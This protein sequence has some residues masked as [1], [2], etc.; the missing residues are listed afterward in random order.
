MGDLGFNYYFLYLG[1]VLPGCDDGE[2]TESLFSI[3]K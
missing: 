3:Q 2:V 1:S